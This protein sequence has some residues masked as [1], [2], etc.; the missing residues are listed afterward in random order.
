[1]TRLSLAEANAIIEG[2]FQAAR[3][4]EGK[5]IA[6]VVLDDA[7]HIVS[8]QRQDGASMFRIDVARG[9]AWG[10]V[11]FGSSSRDLADKAKANP[12][13]I[14]ALAVAAQGKL[15]PNPGAVPI[16]HPDGTLLG[17]VGIS[18]DAGPRDEAFAAAGVEA[19]GLKSVAN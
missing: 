11:A 13:F 17:A 7:G 9:K 8:A 19:A 18:G 12:S 1:M 6:V 2:S 10:A 3:E 4:N 15:L 16:F 5:P 14:Q